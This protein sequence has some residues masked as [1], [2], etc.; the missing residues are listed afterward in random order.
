VPRFT[1]SVSQSC[2]DVQYA[3]TL[4]FGRKVD[5]ASR[6]SSK[7]QSRRDD[8]FISAE[9]SIHSPF[10]IRCSSLR[11]PAFGSDSAENV[12]NTLQMNQSNAITHFKVDRSGKAL[13]FRENVK[14]GTI[15]P[16]RCHALS[17]KSSRP[18]AWL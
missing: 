18:S 5:D 15:A 3:A 16:P 6:A 9:R 10:G 17:N 7:R 12:G 11:H 4:E 8:N 1:Q 14:I 13:P 2:V